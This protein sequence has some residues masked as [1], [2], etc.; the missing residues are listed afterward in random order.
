MVMSPGRSDRR[1][2]HIV[3]TDDNGASNPSVDTQLRERLREHVRKAAAAL[4][5]S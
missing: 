1:W 4:M 3:G 2:V 5:R